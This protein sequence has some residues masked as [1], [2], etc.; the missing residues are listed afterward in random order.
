MKDKIKAV[1]ELI[2]FGAASSII[3][4]IVLAYFSLAI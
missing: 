2:A 3:L 4:L 1:A